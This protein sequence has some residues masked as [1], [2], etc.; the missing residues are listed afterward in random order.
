M[1]YKLVCVCV[2]VCV[3]ACACMC[4]QESTFFETG[5]L[6][7]WANLPSSYDAE[8]R[9][10]PD[11]ITWVPGIQVLMF[12]YLSDWAVSPAFVLRGQNN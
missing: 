10:T 6:T 4:V 9:H 7:N 11:I 12:V 3:C 8:A 5:S 2:C 1:Y